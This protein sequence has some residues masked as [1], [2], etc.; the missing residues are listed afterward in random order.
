MPDGYQ[1]KAAADENLAIYCICN[2]EDS[3]AEF[4][5]FIFFF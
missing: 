5:L 4:L 2:T 1:V 3:H